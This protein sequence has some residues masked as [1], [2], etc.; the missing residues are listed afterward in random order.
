[1]CFV[2]IGRRHEKCQW[3]VP[4]CEHMFDCAECR[5]V[6]SAVRKL[7]AGDPRRLADEDLEE[8][9]VIL[10]RVIDRLQAERLRLVAEV[11]RR[12]SFKRD[13]FVSATA[14]LADRNRTSFGE[15]KRDVMT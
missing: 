11:E 2:R 15:A 4:S 5:A 3:P 12:R 8:G 10:Q 1:M 14:W 9:V 6:E 13:G 7:F